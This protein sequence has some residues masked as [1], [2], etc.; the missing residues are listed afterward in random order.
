MSEFTR[1]W[2]E[3]IR[4]LA[5]LKKENANLRKMVDGCHYIHEEDAKEIDE[6]R[7]LCGEMETRIS[8]DHSGH[9]FQH[10]V[11]NICELIRRAEEILK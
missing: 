10:G 8:I 6:L 3:E 11:C 1:H 2:D 4:T 9:H 7:E 5:N